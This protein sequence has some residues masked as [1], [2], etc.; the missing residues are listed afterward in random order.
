MCTLCS[1]VKHYFILGWRHDRDRADIGA[2]LV[3]VRVRAYSQVITAA[4]GEA[5]PRLSN[6]ILTRTKKGGVQKCRENGTAEGGKHRNLVKV[7]SFNSIDFIGVR[8]GIIK[9]RSWK[10]LEWINLCQIQARLM[11]EV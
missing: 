6:A 8:I 5:P 2:A 9:L 10:R 11:F 1:V 3:H 4:R 7:L